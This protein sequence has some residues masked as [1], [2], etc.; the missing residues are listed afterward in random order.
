MAALNVARASL[1]AFALGWFL[2]AEA[3]VPVPPL[4][5]RVTDLTATL[6][7]EQR[8]GLER[9]LE[10]FEARKGSQVAVLI[11][12]STAPE[13][14]EQ[15]ALRVAEKWKLGRKNVDDGAL[16]VIA[17][18]DRALRI[19][20]G[21]GLEGALTDAASKR[22][23]SEIIAPRFRQEDYFGGIA[24]GVDR[25]LRVIDGEPLPEPEGKLP[26]GSRGIWP[27]LPV[28]MVLAF[29]VGGVLHTTLGRF[30]GAIVTGVTVSTVA[31]L[32][33]GAVAVALIAG[34]IAFLFTLFGGAMDGR[35]LGGGGLGGGGFGGGGFRGGGG[36][37]G[38]GGG[39]G[40]GGGRFGGGGASGRW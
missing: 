8:A 11:V 5:G 36:F 33:V 9:T 15:Y 13:T 28:L 26:R 10:A 24:A 34:V 30:P 3:Q 27:I 20:V 23:I 7:T 37:G 12:P 17:R 6:T 21:Y 14:I 29:V 25:I 16:L 38:G 39:F 40:G 18:D 22:I 1:F 2:V 4:A 31:W 19:E 32:L 35:S